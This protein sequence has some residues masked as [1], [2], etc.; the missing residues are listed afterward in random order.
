MTERAKIQLKEHLKVSNEA[1]KGKC[2]NI[3]DALLEGIKREI[4]N[5]PEAESWVAK[6]RCVDMSLEKINGHHPL[7]NA[8][9]VADHLTS[10]GYEIKVVKDC[11]VIHVKTEDL[12]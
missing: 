12:I 4:N 6:F 8:D 11:V 7:L 5:D 1:F 9:L 2:D 10:R 3:L